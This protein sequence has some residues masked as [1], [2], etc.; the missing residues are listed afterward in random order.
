VEK[1][2]RAVIVHE[3]PLTAGAGAEI[4][5]LIAEKAFHRLKSPIRRIAG[6]DVPIPF[7]PVMESYAIPSADRIEG[8]LRKALEQWPKK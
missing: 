7:A 8:E 4:A 2:G 5:A 6:S 1:T 3:A